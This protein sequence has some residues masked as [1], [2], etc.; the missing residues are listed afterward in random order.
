[1][2]LRSGVSDLVIVK[3]GRAYFLELKIGNGKQSENQCTFEADCMIAQ[4]HYGIA[5]SFDDAVKILQ[6]WRIIP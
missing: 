4:A 5:W 2:G 6:S 3:E 1:M